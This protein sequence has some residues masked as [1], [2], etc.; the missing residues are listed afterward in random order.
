M[1]KNRFNTISFLSDYGIKDG[2]VGVI[3]SVIKSVA[4]EVSV[5]DLSHAVEPFDVKAAGLLLAR[6]ADYLVPGVV[7]ASVNPGNSRHVVI[8][9][10]DG[11]S[12][13]VGPDN[14]VFAPVVAMVGGATAAYELNKPEHFLTSAGSIS[15]GRD[16]YAPIAAKICLGVPLDELAE[17]IDPVKLLPAI[18]AVS[19]SEVEDKI[20][21]E[22]FWIDHFG[23]I[24]LNV[25]PS[26]IKDWDKQISLD[27]NKVKRNVRIVESYSDLK[28]KEVGVVPDSHGLIS[29]VVPRD[30]AAAI[31]KA[32]EGDQIEL[33]NKSGEDAPISV[34]VELKKSVS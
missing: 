2:S 32:S 22:I 12:F 20:S 3:K 4:S 28:S 23:N 34:S 25:E 33:L 11:Q 21:A 5:I 9:I 10:G 29:I 8:E 14:S 17:K 30:S 15:A 31:L 13:L 16:I 19:D 27:I 18:L 1:N 6:A 26:Q 24:Q 7:I